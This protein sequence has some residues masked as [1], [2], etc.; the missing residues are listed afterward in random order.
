[1]TAGADSLL[2]VRWRGG[3]RPIAVEEDFDSVKTAIASP[4]QTH[5]FIRVVGDYRRRVTILKASI[6]FV[7]ETEE[8]TVPLVAAFEPARARFV[9]H[10]EGGERLPRRGR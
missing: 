1:M 2:T 6:A 9:E 10:V 8:A 5:E 7:E 3:E 4:R